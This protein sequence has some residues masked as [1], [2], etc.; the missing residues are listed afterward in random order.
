MSRSGY[1]DECNGWDLIRWR[2]A[3]NSALRGKRGQE[4]L[5]EILTALDAMPNKALA[6]DS[7]VTVDGQYC[8]LGALGAM[9]GIS[10]ENIDPYDLDKVSEVFGMAPAMTREIVYE[11]DEGSN[12]QETPE[13]RWL[14][15]RAWVTANILPA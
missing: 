11:N 2:G 1:S 3:V 6:A 10:L 12:Y 14:R 5:R 9:R 15:M 13:K 7:L 4:A 8:T